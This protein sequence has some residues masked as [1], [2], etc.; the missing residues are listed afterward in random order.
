MFLPTKK[1]E[2]LKKKEEDIKQFQTTIQALEN[3][4]D[5]LTETVLMQKATIEEQQRQLDDNQAKTKKA[6]KKLL[7]KPF[8]R[9][10]SGLMESVGE[11]PQNTSTGLFLGITF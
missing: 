10:R 5:V 9:K 7:K 1:K 2:T 8:V 3:E 11:Q 6:Y 4:R